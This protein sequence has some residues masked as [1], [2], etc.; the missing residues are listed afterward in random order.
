MDQQ[1]VWE[2]YLVL[3]T[4][5]KIRQDSYIMIILKKKRY[6]QERFVSTFFINMR[7]LLFINMGIKMTTTRM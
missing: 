3:R 1:Y 4:H 6:N 7:V 5:M 2:L